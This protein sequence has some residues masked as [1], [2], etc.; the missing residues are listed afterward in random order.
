MR[1]LRFSDSGPAVALLQLALRRAQFGPLETDGIFGLRTREAL[2]RFQAANALSADGVAGRAT[3]TA[4]LP[5]YTG[6][7]RHRVRAGESFWS[8]ARLYGADAAAV[9]LAN[10][11]YRAANLP[12]GARIT[13]PLP[14]PVVPAE[15]PYC[16]SLVAYCVR[17]LA[18]RYPFLAPSSFGRSV[19]GR[20][21][22][23]LSLGAGDNRV[24]YTAAHHANEWITTPLLLSFAEEL[25]AA[26][27]Q[28]GSL[29]G[30][31]AAE[32]LDYAH[33]CLVPLVDPDGVDLVTGELQRGEAFEQ[34]KAIA[35]RY[36]AYAF[37]SGWKA[38]L[39]GTDLNLQYPAGW[40]AA[41]AIKAAAGIVGPAPADF[42]GP[43]PLSAPESRALAAF[44]RRFDPALV[45]AW[46]TQGEVIYWRFSDI[47]VPGA[48]DI[49]ATFA[50]VSGYAAE[51]TPYAS[52]FAGFR[53][54]FIQEFR[55]PG[56]TIEAGRGVNPLP[57]G[58]LAEIRR[59]ALGILTLGALV[60]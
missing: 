60:T 50:A 57:L 53:D 20:P 38:N 1:T 16:A 32:L 11:E 31:S 22:W 26:F 33:L 14:F 29:F 12:V 54:W 3:H 9:E 27:A 40:E 18:A 51:E 8:V 34:A 46:H 4:L 10:P 45:Q 5:W 47:E 30:Q 58:D 2:L 39:R 37:P 17:G 49:A 21:L 56:F 43:A 52:G 55:R 35:S 6:F 28:G 44:T 23:A 7:V 59:R 13:V 15:I 24:L 25:A 48:Q 42:V 41:R 36:P 19:L